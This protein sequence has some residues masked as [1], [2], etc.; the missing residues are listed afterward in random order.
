LGK[1]ESDGTESYPTILG[2]HLL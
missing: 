1:E 2:Q